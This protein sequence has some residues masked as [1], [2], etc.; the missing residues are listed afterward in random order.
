MYLS[1]NKKLFCAFIDYRKAF[2]FVDRCSVWSKLIAVGINGKLLSVIRYLY[3]KAK[4]CV[5]SNGKLSDYFNCNIGVRQGENLSPL[6]F[7]IFLNDFEFSVSRQYA[8]LSELGH[9]INQILSDDDVEHFL[10]IYVLLYADDTIVLAE[11]SSELQKALDAVHQYCENW[12]LTVNTDKT[13][14]VIFSKCKM[15]N[16]PAFLFGHK[17]IQVVDDYVYLGIKSNYNGSFNKAISKQV[18]Q[19]KKAFYGLLDE[20]YKLCLPVDISLELFDQLVLPVLL[21][22]CE[23]WGFGNII[24]IEILHQKYIKLL[25]GIANFTSNIMV[26]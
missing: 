4:S 12:K 22:G 3:C 7:A 25:L 11:S 26:Y 18:L 9:D 2:D 19:G 17:I 10:K 23:V 1:K 6:L 20:V 24:Q 14:I 13:K 15:Q 16:Y 8:G 21:Y 5:K